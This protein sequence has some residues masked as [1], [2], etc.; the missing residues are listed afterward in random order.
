MK[1]IFKKELRS[2]FTSPVGY[3]VM[4][5][6][7]IYASLIFS[8]LLLLY[9]VSDIQFIFSTLTLSFFIIPV[10]T[11]K[12]LAEEKRAK[13]DQLLL[14][15]PISV[16]DIVIG[17]VLAAF[18]MYAI[19]TLATVVFAII[20]EIFGSVSWSIVLSS[21]I[22]IL[23]TGLIYVSA[24]VF[25]SSVTENQIVAA[26]LSFAFVLFASAYDSFIVPAFQNEIVF[27]VLNWFSINMRFNDFYYGIISFE[28]VVY[29]LSLIALFIVLTVS[30]IE[31]RRFQK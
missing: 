28:T 25:I 31:K 15:A 8:S 29:Y 6:Y 26:V 16:S 7:F 10:I 13:T 27:S 2:Y 3:V 19:P 18:T 24:G 14:T 30:G 9:G 12:T 4:A 23:L 22:G 11:M 17:K 21:Y 1:A 5:V 20:F